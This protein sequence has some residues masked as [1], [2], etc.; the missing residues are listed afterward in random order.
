MADALDP[1]DAIVRH[2]EQDYREADRIAAGFDSLELVRTQEILRRH[3][4]PAPAAVLDVGG[5]TG[6]HASWLA[7][8]GYR[9]HIVD[10]VP[11]HVERAQADL[12]SLGVTA[13]VGDARE[14]ANADASV[15][16]TLV[17]GPL[18]HLLSRADRVAALAEARRVTRPGG[19]V[20]IAAVSRFASVASGLQH[21]FLLD[22]EFRAIVERDLREGQ[23]RN[24][25]RRPGW[26]TTAFFHHPDELRDEIDA[27]GLHL[28]ELVGVEG[29]AVWLD[30]A[31]RWATADG[32]EAILFAARAVESEPSLLGVS[33]HL[34][35]IARTADASV[36][37]I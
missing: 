23:H 35:A 6:V 32:R 29:L 31:D 15:D 26:F 14:L 30:L 27:A 22:P 1:S 9:V 13:E 25:N 34:L 33:P 20:A 2:Y 11:L 10:L 8:D 19:L 24:D 28:V 3:L 7:A 18:Y 37:P 17:L 16:V 5:A 4:P 12:A 36:D 21:G